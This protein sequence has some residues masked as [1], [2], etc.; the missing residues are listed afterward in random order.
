MT[1]RPCCVP[2]RSRCARHRP[3]ARD[4]PLCDTAVVGEGLRVLVVEDDGRIASMLQKGLRAR[5]HVPEV[6][7]TGSDALARVAAGGVDVQLLD[8]GLP[9]I[10]GLEVL[11]RLAEAGSEVP[12]VVITAR[13]DPL[14]REEAL[15]LG[16][17][18]YITKPFSW[19][20]VWAALDTCTAL[21]P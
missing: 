12:V 13:S 20:D 9:D 14:D 2:G 16:A 4:G 1:A 7:A 21:R 10:D 11:R 15:A 5:G 8:L 19:A 3:A 17:H 6:V 18:A